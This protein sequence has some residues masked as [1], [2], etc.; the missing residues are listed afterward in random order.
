M[1]ILSKFIAGGMITPNLTLFGWA[2]LLL[3]MPALVLPIEVA[4]H[5]HMNNYEC[6]ASSDARGAMQ[7]DDNVI[8]RRIPGVGYGFLGRKVVVPAYLGGPNVTRGVVVMPETGVDPEAYAP[9][10]RGKLKINWLHSH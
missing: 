4:I 6:R 10:A 5:P 2:H 1:I 3:L 9:L 7:S 8:L